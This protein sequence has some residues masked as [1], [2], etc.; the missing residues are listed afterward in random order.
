MQIVKAKFLKNNGQNRI[1]RVLCGSDLLADIFRLQYPNASTFLEISP[2]IGKLVC[3]AYS[4]ERLMGLLVF[5][6]GHLEKEDAKQIS[7]EWL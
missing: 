2:S 1:T 3:E 5:R 7:W 6:N 4:G